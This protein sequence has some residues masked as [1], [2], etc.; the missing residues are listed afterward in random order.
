[1]PQESTRKNNKIPSNHYNRKIIVSTIEKLLW[2]LVSRVAF[3]VKHISISVE[4]SSICNANCV[5]CAYQFFPKNREK[6]FIPENVFNQVI[7]EVKAVKVQKIHL[8]PDLGEPTLSPGFI[9]KIEAFREAGVKKV[10]L[11]TNAIALH[12]IGIDALLERGPDIINISTTGFDA[13]MFWR[14]Y[15]CQGYEI[16]RKNLIEL[17]EKNNRRTFPREINIWLRIDVPVKEAMGLPGM[18]IVTSLANDVCWMTEVDSWNGRIKQEMLP[19]TLRIQTTRGKLTRRPCRTLLSLVIRVNGGVNACSCRN[20][21]N[22]THLFLG[23]LMEQGLLACFRR[24]GNVIKNWRQGKFPD[25]CK[26]CDMYHDP[27]DRIVDY[28]VRYVRSI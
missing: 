23:N 27:R 12:K 2:P 22:D 16:M 10:E 7:R 21:E 13:A 24:L 25:V 14:I 5:F 17:L 19:G 28:I 20:I 3:S 6:K 18:E 15:R 11:T 26:T 9:D 1:M 4:L 8:S